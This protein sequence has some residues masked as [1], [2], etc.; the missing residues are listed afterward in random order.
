MQKDVNRRPRRV[1]EIHL[2]VWS[3]KGRYQK[4]VG[5]CAERGVVAEKRDK[6]L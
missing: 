4:L 3:D 6:Q 1:A 5:E 2:E